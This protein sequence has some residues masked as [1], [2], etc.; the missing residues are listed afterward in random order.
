LLIGPDAF[1]ALGWYLPQLRSDPL[2]TTFRPAAPRGYPDAWTTPRRWAGDT[3]SPFE[4]MRVLNPEPN[5]NRV[6]RL[7]RRMRESFPAL[8]P[9][10]IEQAWAGMIDTMP[11]TLPVVD[12][13]AA[14]PGLTIATGMS[15][16]G[17]GIGPAFGR[18][19]ADLALGAEPGHDLTRFRLA[20]FH[21]GSP[22]VPAAD[23]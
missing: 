9:V 12:R 17:F 15:G 7:A 8:G 18:I 10:G 6:K 14:L 5:R 1:R 16:H 19:A 3:V 13:A 11:D 22:L 2:G 4:R 20:R 21:G 23:L